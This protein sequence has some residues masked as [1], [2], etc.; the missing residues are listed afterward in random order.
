[1]GGSTKKLRNCTYTLLSSINHW[2][3]IAK[4][5][6]AKIFAGGMGKALQKWHSAGPSANVPDMSPSSHRGVILIP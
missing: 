5:N 2:D 1:M 4:R 6:N 3:L